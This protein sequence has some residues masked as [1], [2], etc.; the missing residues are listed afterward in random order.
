MSYAIFN[1][2]QKWPFGRIPFSIDEL[3]FPIGSPERTSIDNAVNAWNAGTAV[4]RIVPRTN[5]PDYVH[6]IPDLVLARRELAAQADARKLMQPISQPFLPTQLCQRS[7]SLPI[8]W[9]VSISMG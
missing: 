9:T 8:R 4:V 1:G 6:F 2:T 5:D 7:T 3:S